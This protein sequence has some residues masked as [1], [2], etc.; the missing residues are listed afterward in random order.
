[1]GQN[2]SLNGKKENHVENLLKEVTDGLQETLKEPAGRMFQ[3]TKRAE[4]RVKYAPTEEMEHRLRNEIFAGQ[5]NVDLLEVERAI[6]RLEALTDRRTGYSIDLNELVACAAG[7]RGV[8][9]GELLPKMWKH[10]S[11]DAKKDPGNFSP[12]LEDDDQIP[13]CVECQKFLCH[14]VELRNAT[15][16]G[17]CEVCRRLNEQKKDGRHNDHA[18]ENEDNR[19]IPFPRFLSCDAAQA[20]IERRCYAKQKAEEARLGKE[21]ARGEREEVASKFLKGLAE[22]SKQADV[23]WAKRRY[24]R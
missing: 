23:Q 19:T 1:M 18:G 7:I 13:C 8:C 9:V 16:V 24:G 5:H 15:I 6:F 17:K 10:K 11:G 4:F 21:R 22:R 20:A 14:R 3:F 12:D 2:K